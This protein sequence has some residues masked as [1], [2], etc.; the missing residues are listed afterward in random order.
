MALAAALPGG[1][2]AHPASATALF[3]LAL[4]SSALAQRGAAGAPTAQILVV[5][6]GLR[7]L[8]LLGAPSL[9]DDIFR[10]V[11]EGRA[12]RLGLEVPFALPPVEITPPP[13]DGTT[14]RVNHPEIP[15][16]YPPLSQLFFLVTV[17]AG[18]AVSAPRLFLRAA[19]VAA[20]LLVVW[21]LWRQ[22]RERPL[23]WSRYGLHVL[24]LLEAGLSSHIDAL[25]VALL[26]AGALVATSP[27]W[28]GALFGLAMGVKP[29]ALLGLLS[30]RLRPRALAL[31]SAGLLVGALL[32]AAP[33]LAASAPLSRG[34]V[35]YSTRWQAQPTLYALLEATLA[36]AF[37]ERAERGVYAHL[38]VAR[39]P[40][41]VLVEEAGR[42]R[43]EVGDA[44]PVARPLLLDARLFARL[45][46]LALFAVVTGLL[47]VR[48]RDPIARL[49]A[50]LAAFWLLS[51]TLHPWYLLWVLPFA[52]FLDARGILWWAA[53]APLTYEAAL[54][55]AQT[56]T[57]REALWP[58]LVMLL[59]LAVGTFFDV[60]ARRSTR[61]LERGDRPP[62]EE[63]TPER[64]HHRVERERDE[65]R[66]K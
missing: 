53:T 41:G 57:W 52:A 13:D 65:A 48:V 34:L 8:A 26:A 23:A 20:D 6:V 14:A 11:H 25:G 30:L 39:A 40:F 55:Y 15:A 16:A 49:T 24:P 3:L 45:L 36:P 29:V 10:Y 1:L 21:L 38:H 28:R 35:E 31:A 12:S 50:A 56:S 46:S 33:Y 58:R 47:L 59:A 44:R 37:R 17:A 64:R 66:A 27:L 43:L 42:A 63:P 62:G 22:R 2:P 5:V 32:P 18:D 61:G 60:R 4:A 9:S 54:A 19:L 51:P 7:V